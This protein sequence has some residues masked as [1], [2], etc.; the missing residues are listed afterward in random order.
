MNAC[1]HQS[2]IALMSWLGWDL[3]LSESR[4]GSISSSPLMKIVF[5]FD[6]LLLN[7]KLRRVSQ[8]GF[9]L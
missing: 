3:A 5:D 1:Q 2:G 6:L 7:I 9:G 8:V 4:M